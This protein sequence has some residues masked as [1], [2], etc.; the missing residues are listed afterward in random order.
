MPS[1]FLE[2]ELARYSAGQSCDGEIILKD[3]NP[4]QFDDLVIDLLIMYDALESIKNNSCCNP[5]SEAGLVAKSALNQVFRN[6]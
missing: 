5:C 1:V 4:A 2:C 3:G 6:A